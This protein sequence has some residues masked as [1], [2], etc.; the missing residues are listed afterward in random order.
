MRRRKDTYVKANSIADIQELMTI[1]KSQK[2]YHEDRIRILKRRIEDI[3]RHILVVRE[4]FLSFLSSNGIDP[5]YP[6][7]SDVTADDIVPCTVSESGMSAIAIEEAMLPNIPNVSFLRTINLLKKKYGSLQ[8]EIEEYCDTLSK[9]R[10]KKSQLEATLESV[11]KSIEEYQDKIRDNQQEYN[12]SVKNLDKIKSLYQSILEFKTIFTSI[13][14]NFTTESYIKFQNNYFDRYSTLYYGKK[15][16]VKKYADILHDTYQLTSIDQME[17]GFYTT[18]FSDI[19]AYFGQYDGNNLPDKYVDAIP[20]KKTILL[21]LEDFSASLDKLI[22]NVKSTLDVVRGVKG[23]GNS[24]VEGLVNSVTEL[25]KSY[26]AENK[27]E[28]T[29]LESVSS[30]NYTNNISVNQNINKIK[31]KLQMGIENLDDKFISSSGKFLRKIALSV[32]F[33]KTFLYDRNTNLE[34]CVRERVRR[35]YGGDIPFCDEVATTDINGNRVFVKKSEMDS[36]TG[37]S[38]V[39]MQ[40][41]TLEKKTRTNRDVMA[42]Y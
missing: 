21:K 39:E 1:A 5:N 8:D 7:M 42:S 30:N 14:D 3:N 29:T 23:I 40:T 33:P 31:D 18:V 37:K 24:V 41:D 15:N 2:E 10:L 27:V 6:V 12:D 35:K 17:E 19:S 26:V 20:Y 36:K 4:D 34:D 28:H 25:S 13:P 38:T 16:S 11:Q 9:M 22:L 32:G